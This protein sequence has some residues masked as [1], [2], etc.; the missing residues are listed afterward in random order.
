MI[1][2]LHFSHLLG[3][4]NEAASLLSRLLLNEALVIWLHTTGDSED[5]PGLVELDPLCL[6][7]T[8]LIKQLW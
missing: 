5:K 3:C 1:S 7:D 6:T 8:L 4:V 2:K